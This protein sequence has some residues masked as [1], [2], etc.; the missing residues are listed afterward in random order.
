MSLLDALP[1]AAIDEQ[2]LRLLVSNRLAESLDLKFK[3]AHRRGGSVRGRRR[4]RHTRG[5][6]YDC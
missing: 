5:P 4:G 6:A 3:A 2:H 1:L